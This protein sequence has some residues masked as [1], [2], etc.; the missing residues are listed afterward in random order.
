MDMQLCDECNIN[1]ANIHLTQI[2][3]NEVVVQHLCETCARSKGI[4]IV[5][6]Q[7]HALPQQEGSTPQAQPA[8]KSGGEQ[9]RACPSCHLRYPEFREKGRLGCAHC[10]TAF[11]KELDT[12]LIQVHGASQH[13]GKRYHAVC[14]VVENSDDIVML[15]HELDNAI[16]S[17]KFEL[18]AQIRDRIHRV[19]LHE[20]TDGAR[21]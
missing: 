18:A 4:S 11:E 3:Q 14:N 1:P 6:E 15:R 8:P 20:S 7:G 5:I 12:L 19:S 13:R 2:T 10:Y 17:E 9:E 21:S 16:R